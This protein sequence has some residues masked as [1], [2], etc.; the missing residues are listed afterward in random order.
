[1]SA[2]ASSRLIGTAFCVARKLTVSRTAIFIASFRSSSK[3]IRMK[4]VGVSARGQSSFMSLRTIV[5]ST[6]SR[7]A[8][9]S[10]VRLTSPLPCRQCESPVH[11]NAPGTCTGT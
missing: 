10:A 5:C 8:H 6:I 1:M 7:Y 9:S 4:C 3:P 2:Y 11:S